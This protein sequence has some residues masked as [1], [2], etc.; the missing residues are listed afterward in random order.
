MRAFVRRRTEPGAHMEEGLWRYSRHPNYF[1]EI[2]FWISLWLF[3]MAASPEAWW[4]GIGALAMIVMFVFA[5]VPMMEERSL[6][7]RPGYAEYIRRTS[8]FIPRP[9]KA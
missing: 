6:A 5:S 9:P 3:A 8:A 4:T 2:L 7:R 1:G